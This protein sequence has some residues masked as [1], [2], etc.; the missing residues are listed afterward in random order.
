MKKM[1]IPP[2]QESRKER[3]GS[4][5]SG[6]ETVEI[7][8]ELNVDNSDRSTEIQVSSN[9]GNDSL[10]FI[11]VAAPFEEAPDAPPCNSCGDVHIRTPDGLAYDFQGAGEYLL[12]ESDDGSIVIQARQEA[13]SESNRV[14]VNT[15][16][17]ANV[18]GDRIGV[19]VNRSPNLYV[20]G[21]ETT[22]NGDRL[23]MPNGGMI[24]DLPHPAI[25]LAGLQASL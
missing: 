4:S 23:T 1:T 16:L 11:Q 18:A 14:S 25:N 21:T 22:R 7:T 12:I 24:Y 10:P 19:Y 8:Y 17:A 9:V 6:S 5:S 20:N 15:A 3:S 13:W 2:N